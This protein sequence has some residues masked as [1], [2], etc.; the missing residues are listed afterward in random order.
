MPRNLMGFAYVEGSGGKCGRWPAAAWNTSPLHRKAKRCLKR[1]RPARRVY[2]V[3]LL[4][5]VWI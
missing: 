4:A 2:W 3:G 1:N 5:V